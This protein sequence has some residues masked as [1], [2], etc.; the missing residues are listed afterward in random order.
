VL[1]EDDRFLQ[2]HDV[3]NGDA[4]AMCPECRHQFPIEMR[5]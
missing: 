4:D 3:V 2:N 5:F 1:K